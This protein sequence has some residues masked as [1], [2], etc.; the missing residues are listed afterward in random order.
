MPNPFYDCLQE[1]QQLPEPVSKS[2]VKEIMIQHLAGRRVFC[3]FSP[4][5]Y[6]KAELATRLITRGFKKADAVR[7]LINSFEISK[8]W[9][10]SLV[11]DA[12]EAKYQQHISQDGFVNSSAN[13]GEL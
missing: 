9:A 13:I 1:I 8:T 5:R 10:Y 11:N 3:S 7:I 2:A 12:I 4:E 6:Q